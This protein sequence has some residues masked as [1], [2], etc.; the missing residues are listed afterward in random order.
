MSNFS[1]IQN[2]IKKIIQSK[3]I[4]DAEI[5]MNKKLDSAEKEEILANPEVFL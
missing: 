2:E 1:N 3:T 5:V 4:R